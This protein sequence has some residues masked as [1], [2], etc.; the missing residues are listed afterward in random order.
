MLGLNRL[1]YWGG[2]GRYD[3]FGGFE[4]MGQYL[5]YWWFGWAFWDGQGRAEGEFFGLSE[6]IGIGFIGC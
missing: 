2:A 5:R 3:L 1:E 6:G 4:E